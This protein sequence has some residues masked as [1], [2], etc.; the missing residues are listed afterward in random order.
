MAV[1]AVQYTIKVEVIE[2]RG[3]SFKESAGEKEIVP[4]PYVDVTVGGTTKSTVQKNQV[5]SATFNASFNFQAT[6]TPEEFQRSYVELAVMHRYTLLGGVGLQSALIGKY[7]FSFACVYSK[8]QH[9][10]YRQWIKLN[11]F[12]QLVSDPGMMLLTVGVFGPG[13]PLPVIDETVAYVNEDGDR[14]TKEVDVKSTYYNLTVNIYKGQDISEVVGQITTTCEPFIKVRHGGAELQTRSLPEH[15]PEWQASISLPASMPCHDDTVLVELWNG[16]SSAV[17]MATMVLDFFELIKNETPTRWFNFY[18]RPPT[19]GLLGAV[20]DMLT[21]AELRQ[22]NAYAGRILLN[23]S[24]VKVQ[25]PLP[26]G[27]RPV[28]AVHEPP[29]VEYVLWVDVYEVSCN[30]LLSNE[31]QVEVSFGPHALK[32]PPVMIEEAGSY[33]LEA[34]QGRM[35]ELKVYL[36]A[37]DAQTWAFFLYISSISSASAAANVAAN[38][39]NWFGGLAGVAETDQN[40]EPAVRT[41]RLAWAMIPFS[42]KALQDGKPMWYSL[43]ATDGSGTD[44]FSVL[45]SITCRP[46]RTMGE[47]PARLQYNLQRYYFRALIYEGLHLPAVGYDQFPNP[48]IKIVLGSQQL[49]TLTFRQTLNPS[50]YEAMEMEVILPE[51]MQLAPDIVLEVCSESD[52]IM[53]SDIVLGSTTYPIQKVPKEWKKAPVWLMLQSKQY[54]RCKAKVLVAFEL[55]PAELVENDTYPFFDDI[56][57][58]TK[59][60]TVSIFLVGVRLFSPVQ[61][62]YVEV[63][64]GRDVEDT[65]KPLWSERT[66]EPHVGEGG[67]WNFLQ[68][69]NVGVSLPK[70][71][72]HHCFM[73]VKVLD[74]V[75]GISGRTMKDVGMAYI[76]L[77]PLLPWLEQ[78]ERE[79]T[80]EMFKLQ[81]MEEVMIEDAENARRISDGV[82]GQAGEAKATGEETASV[83]ARLAMAAKL[84]KKMVVPYNDPDAANCRLEATDDYV[85]FGAAAAP[86]ATRAFTASLEKNETK[87]RARGKGF[88]GGLKMKKSN[89]GQLGSDADGAD[90][91]NELYGFEPEALDFVLTMADEDEVEENMRDEI[92]YEMETDFGVNDLP[93]LRVPIF[94]CT[95]CG[96]PETI[97]YLKYICRVYQGE[98]CGSEMEEMNKLCQDL[99]QKYETTRELVVRAYVLAARGL[100]PP[101]GASDIQTYVWIYNSSSTATLS[102]GLTH[103]L[104]DSGHVKKQGFKP[105]FNRC[106]GLA[107]SLPEHAVVQ[108]AIMNQGRVMDECVGKTFI[109]MEDRFFNPKVAAMVE[110]EITPIE[111]RTL[112]VEGSTVSHGTLRGFFEIMTE[113]YAQEHPQFTLASAEADDFQL[114]LVIWRVKAVPLDDNSSVSMF[115]R[116]IFTLEENSEIVHDTDTHYNSKDG[117]GVFNWRCVFDVKIPAPIPVL[118]VQIWNYAVLSSGEPIGECNFDLTADFFRARK[119]GQIYRLPR[120][121]LRCTHPAF[122]GKSRGSVEVEASILP[123]KEADYSPVGQGREE[124]NRDPFLPAVTQNRTYVDWEAINETVGAASSAIMSGLKWTGV[125]MAV[126]GVI[127]IVIFIMFL[128]K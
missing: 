118:K 36:P 90:N 125:W 75:E 11:N 19:E 78:R 61:R 87:P 25:A 6:L 94:R 89:G 81:V 113:D 30:A 127:A 112:K 8:S 26:M 103:N 18:W 12:E 107:C 57:P 53:S 46:A 20:H 119:R 114:R 52:S 28:R 58:S 59:E 47:R 99:V 14:V 69:F 15:S 79:E 96:V 63:C 32:S 68:H 84:D 77:N 108:V 4:N 62:P 45:V 56:R 33:T 123:L 91:A 17:L 37:D 73:E 51:M 70:R 109:D 44:P 128:L 72:Q 24:C 40:A 54:P 101:S 22:A 74:E 35:E 65:T 10:M 97:G 67:N 105:E 31:L 93:Y 124:P 5:V 122:K 9:W 41:S 39:M 71:M 76:T 83:Q 50:Y 7:V 60:A 29:Q 55:V 48:Y 104:K 92:P 102:G 120:F 1:R 85:A 21:N 66:R 80:R 121:W 82:A 42:T 43:R 111:L 126:A 116:S 3:L 38:V 110:Q 98:E 13:D 49:K 117:S 23:A 86:V 64:F 100:V 2:V 95:D 115:V 27:V 34:E 106:Y 88:L 16:G